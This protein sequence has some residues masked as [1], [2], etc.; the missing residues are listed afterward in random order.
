MVFLSKIHPSRKRL[1]GWL[2]DVSSYRVSYSVA[3]VLS[4]CGGIV[5]FA[6]WWFDRD[7]RPAALS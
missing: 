1:L 5:F 3:A 4:V 6:A 7:K 2:D